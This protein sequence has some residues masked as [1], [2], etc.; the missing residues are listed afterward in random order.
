MQSA[1]LS[2]QVAAMLRSPWYRLQLT[3]RWSCAHIVVHF[4]GKKQTSFVFE[5]I[6]RIAIYLLGLTINNIMFDKVVLC[7]IAGLVR[8][9]G[10]I[11]RRF[12][13]VMKL[14]HGPH[15]P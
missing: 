6:F 2:R 12:G 14:L 8:H 5:R 11:V 9:A 1:L 10:W 4:A 13:F 3:T 15:F 7:V